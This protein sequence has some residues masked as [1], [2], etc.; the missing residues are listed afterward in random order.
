M[1]N[2]LSFSKSHDDTRDIS[3]MDESSTSLASNTTFERHSNHTLIA[4]NNAKT[5]ITLIVVTTVK[6]IIVYHH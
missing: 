1:Y 3:Y 6:I 5:P 4:I 2:V